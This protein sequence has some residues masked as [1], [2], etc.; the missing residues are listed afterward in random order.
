MLLVRV[1]YE[2]HRTLHC[3]G[4]LTEQVV[5][6]HTLVLHRGNDALSVVARTGLEV[7]REAI[8][9]TDECPNSAW[10]GFRWCGT[11]DVHYR[12]CVS[13]ALVNQVRGLRFV[14]NRAVAQTI[15]RMFSR[16][17]TIVRMLSD[18]TVSGGISR[19]AFESVSGNG[20]MSFGSDT[21]A[22]TLHHET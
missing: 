13:I 10:E 4:E 15:S 22:S 20:L 7:R 11:I 17:F 14:H 9:W 3:E 6:Q 16:W 8:E 19:G 1:K 5:E 12:D 21:V 2:R 18:T